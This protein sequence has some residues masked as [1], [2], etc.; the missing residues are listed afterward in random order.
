MS[1]RDRLDEICSALIEAV[2]AGAV[3]VLT[4]KL[5]GDLDVRFKDAKELVTAADKQSDAAILA[6]FHRRLTAIDPDISFQLEESG[7]TGTCDDKR[8]GADPIDGTTHFASGGHWYSVQAHYVE[9]GVPLVGV[10][11]QPEVYLPLEESAQCLGR[12]AWAIRGRGAWVRRSEFVLGK[13]EFAEARALRKRSAP[14]TSAL[15]S[16]V[17]LGTKMTAEEREQAILIY[18]SGIAS[19]STGTGCAGG[20]VMMTIFGGQHVYA[21]FGAG[22]DLD[23]I[24][25]QVIAEEAG[26]IVWGADRRPPVWR[27][28][29]QPF[30]VAPTEEIAERF[31]Q[32]AGF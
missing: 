14:P 9:A 1:A 12:M 24:P 18:T 26:M 16:C 5:A 30:V 11:F 13:F 27:V 6:V 19:V 32:A 7:I 15:L 25:P 21:N 29:K 31:F 2:T 22:E 28:R 17:P 8:A 10:V 3:E 23:L 4:V 20:N